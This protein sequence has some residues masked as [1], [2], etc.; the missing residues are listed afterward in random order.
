MAS[1]KRPA[2]D[3]AQDEQTKQSTTKRVRI[4]ADASSNKKSPKDRVKA[5][6]ASSRSSDAMD[7]TSSNPSTLGLGEFN[8]LEL[9]DDM[10]I[11]E[12][13]GVQIRENVEV[14]MEDVEPRGYSGLSLPVNPFDQPFDK[15]DNSYADLFNN[16]FTKPSDDFKKHHE[17]S[18]DYKEDVEPLIDFKEHIEPLDDFMD[19]VKLSKFEPILPSMREV[20][21][22]R[23]AAEKAHNVDLTDDEEP[24]HDVGVKEVYPNLPKRLRID[25]KTPRE[26]RAERRRAEKA[27][28]VHF[29]EEEED[30]EEEE[31]V[32][33]L[34]L[35]EIQ[36]AP[37]TA[38]TNSNT[39]TKGEEET[40]GGWPKRQVVR[41]RGSSYKTTV[42]EEKDESVRSKSVGDDDAIIRR[43]PRKVEV[44]G[45]DADA[46]GETD[47]EEPAASVSKEIQ[48]DSKRISLTVNVNV[49]GESN[50]KPVKLEDIDFSTG[51]AA[52]YIDFMARQ[53]RDVSKLF[54]PGPAS[55]SSSE[56]EEEEEE[57]EEKE[58]EEEEEED[59]EDG[60]EDEDEDE[61]EYGESEES[62]DFDEPSTNA[63]DNNSVSDPDSP[64][65]IFPRNKSIDK[66]LSSLIKRIARVLN[67]MARARE[68]GIEIGDYQSL[69]AVKQ[70]R[71][72]ELVDSPEHAADFVVGALLQLPLLD[73]IPLSQR[74]AEL[75]NEMKHLGVII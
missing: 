24:E 55:D 51:A 50:K 14:E 65:L 33:K 12:G 54:R 4:V 75:Q 35:V 36:D 23:R 58:E 67:F 53:G 40:E 49:N 22:A 61:D 30:D 72:A 60:D 73:I 9:T 62:D 38:K 25:G 56:E 1:P 26:M 20:R 41:T 28:R 31:R 27:R 44:L 43:E 47:V 46:E 8:N 52:R 7:T 16:L 66:L 69:E 71:W 21:A 11:Q 48:D 37:E 42:S 10:D 5:L 68:S 19:E 70:E 2:Q 32:V 6:R 34:K 45:S 63:G 64:F 18:N 3:H 39:D 13:G 17:P 59:D 29:T 15:F 74:A 57:E